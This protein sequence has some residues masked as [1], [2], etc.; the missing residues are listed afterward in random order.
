MGA[1]AVRVGEVVTGPERV[2][3]R[4]AEREAA[5]RGGPRRG[6]GREGPGREAKSGEETDL[7]QAP[8]VRAG[9]GRNEQSE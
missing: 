5:R 3:R 9:K 7:V 6:P 2:R 1:P 8:S 4:R